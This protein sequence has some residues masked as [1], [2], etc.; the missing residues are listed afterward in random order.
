MR[1][2][3]V[4]GP[5]S[6]IGRATAMELARQDYHVVAAGRS[7]ERVH[8]VVSAILEEGGSAEFLRLDLASLASTRKAAQSFL[9]SGAPLDVLVNNAGVGPVTGATEDGF[10]IH[11]GVNHLG[12][13]LFAQRLAVAMGEG[14]RVVQVSSDMHHR[15][16]GIDFDQLRRQT[17]S[18]LGLKEYAVSKLANVL[19]ARE[20]ARRQ[21]RWRV[22]AVHPGMVDTGIIPAYVKPFLRGRMLTPQQGA[23]TVVWCA[24]S[25]EVA[26]DSGGY[27]LR[28]EAVTPSAPARDDQLAERLWEFSEHWSEMAPRA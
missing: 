4:T 26:G 2:A 10:E 21:P 22:Y 18:F 19:F 5:S 17:R 12:H 11:F 28:R 14:S 20:L 9:V 1:T 7:V 16:P 23:D 3:L 8:P 25:P 15:A 24:T 27:Y 13:F 6:G